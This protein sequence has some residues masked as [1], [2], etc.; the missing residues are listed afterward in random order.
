MKNGAWVV[1]RK[2]M[3]HF[4]GDKRLLFTAVIMPGLLIYILYTVMGM[5]MSAMMTEEVKSFK[6][7]A[8]NMPQYIEEMLAQS[9]FEV[10]HISSDETEKIKQGVADGDYSILAVFPDDFEN[11]LDEYVSKLGADEVP[12][13]EIYY[14]SADINSSQAYM[15][16]VSTLDVLEDSLSNV[17]DINNSGKEESYDLATS[18]DTAGSILGSILPILLMTLMYTSCASLAP[19]S[20]AGEK[21]RGTICALL[22]TPVPRSQ[23]ILGKLMALSLMALLGGISSFVGIFLSVPT[24]MSSV[25]IEGGSIGNISADVY[26]ISDYIKLML[27]I[28]TA[29]MLLITLISIL[30]TIA[31]SVKEASTLVMPLMMTVMLASFMSINVTPKDVSAASL[32]IP[33]YGTVIGFTE[34][35]TF[36]VQAGHLLIAAGTNIVLSGVGIFV[37]TKLFNNEKVMFNG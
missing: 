25:D 7:A 33:I 21:E 20:I 29:V 19:E 30:S 2:E 37:L 13:V 8:V 34:I 18:E 9:E 35:F 27:L 16:L 31:K 5:A 12:N 17:F 1:F 36:S 32:C 14:N 10:Q 3:S 11:A 28:I 24:L 26:K 15:K 6:A 22:I 4:I 23:I